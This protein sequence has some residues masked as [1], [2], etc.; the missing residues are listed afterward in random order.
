MSNSVN[1]EVISYLILKPIIF[2]LVSSLVLSVGGFFFEED[3]ALKV[4]G[5][6]LFGLVS[7]FSIILIIRSIF[8]EKAAIYT[9]NNS[10]FYVNPIKYIRV[11]LDDIIGVKLARNPNMIA[12]VT[13]KGLPFSRVKYIFTFVT[14]LSAIQTLEKIAKIISVRSA[15]VNTR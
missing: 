2:M 3:H 15:S 12:I 9:E 4:C 8:F 11:P 13:N 5:I 6:L 14:D 1:R 10:L 7:I